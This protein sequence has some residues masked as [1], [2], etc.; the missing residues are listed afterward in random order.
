MRWA[1]ITLM[2]K[3]QRTS[4]H[5]Q[6][7]RAPTHDPT[8]IDLLTMLQIG[9]TIAR[10]LNRPTKRHRATYDPHKEQSLQAPELDLNYTTFS[11]TLSTEYSDKIRFTF[12]GKKDGVWLDV[13]KQP[14]FDTSLPIGPTYD[15]IFPPNTEHRFVKKCMGKSYLTPRDERAFVHGTPGLV[16][17]YSNTC[18]KLETNLP[19]SVSNALQAVAKIERDEHHNPN[20]ASMYSMALAVGYRD[21]GDKVDAHQ[22]KGHNGR[23]YS[24]TICDPASPLRIF[25]ILDLKKK[26]L[27]DV[28][29]AN[30]VMMVMGPNMQHKQIGVLHAVP[31]TR[32]R[33]QPGLRVNF[34]IRPI[35][36]TAVHSATDKDNQ[37]LQ[38]QAA[39]VR[40]WNFVQP[41]ADQLATKITL[42]GATHQN[43]L[44]F[45]RI[46][47]ENQTAGHYQFLEQFGVFS[48]WAPVPTN[49]FPTSEHAFIYE[50]LTRFC[51]LSN[52]QARQELSKNNNPKSAKLIGR[53]HRMNGEQ[54]A[55]Y[56]QGG[57]KECMLA[58]LNYKFTQNAD[59]KT[60]LLNTD[61]YLVENAPWDPVWGTGKPVSNT[62]SFLIDYTT[63]PGRNL[64]GECLMSIRS[65]HA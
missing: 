23:I 41:Q 65:S 2:T 7:G 21:G 10:D 6:L 64:L 32:A 56:N 12:A 4:C 57:N 22:D 61:Q 31:R 11:G 28:E 55:L 58:A 40:R 39:A 9:P 1:S 17:T 3:L 35:E 45:C 19:V 38:D 26:K 15:H 14:F 48:N 13:Y 59:V 42:N 47:Q 43:P 24:F 33:A 60:L 46:I 49:G 18:Y 16:Y 53:K 30:G 36:G 51:G 34:T 52:K 20:A 50:K 27:L 25:R 54:L 37:K 8:L 62:D 63:Y 44:L 29:T 5:L